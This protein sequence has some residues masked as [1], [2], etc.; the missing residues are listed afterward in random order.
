M[1]NFYLFPVEF[2]SVLYDTVI[3]L[4]FHMTS[5]HLFLPMYDILKII[6]TLKLNKCIKISK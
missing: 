5:Q 6:M 2:F 3:F 1:P 4:Y